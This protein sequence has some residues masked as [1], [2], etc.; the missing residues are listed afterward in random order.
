LFAPDHNPPPNYAAFL[1]S[2]SG[3]NCTVNPCTLNGLVTTATPTSAARSDGDSTDLAAFLTERLWFTDELSVIGGVRFD[4]FNS[5]FIPVASTN[6]APLLKRNR[7]WFRPAPASVSDPTRQK[8]SFSLGG[9]ARR[10][11][12]AISWAMRRR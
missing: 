3:L 1:Y 6:P 10:R 11:Q 7:N 9:G 2:A 8:H 5:E 12:A 4:K